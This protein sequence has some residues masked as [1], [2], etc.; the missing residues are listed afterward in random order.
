MSK[1]CLAPNQT[2]MI[3]ELKLPVHL[4]WEDI[5]RVTAQM[6]SVDL[7]FF[8]QKPIAATTT[9]TLT[10]TFCYQT[11]IQHLKQQ[12]HQRHFKLIEY[13]A[14]EL[15]VIIKKTVVADYLLTVKVTKW[16]A[17]SNLAGGVSFSCGD[18]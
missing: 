16:P 11:L 8:Y 6:V 1:P 5:E 15:Y 9:D 17:I 10:D 13:L 2:L 3:N 7:C 12:V 14:H 4:G 18:K